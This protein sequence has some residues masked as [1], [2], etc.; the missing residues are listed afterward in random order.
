MRENDALQIYR[1]G[2]IIIT[3]HIK[4]HQP[5]LGEVANFGEKE[6]FSLISIF[7]ATPFDMIAQLD[8]VGIDFTKITD[9]ELFTMMIKNL[10]PDQS[11]ILFGDVNF[12][13]YRTI[14][15]ENG[16]FDLRYYD[17]VI[18]EPV[19]RL[20]AKY[21]RQIHC[22]A[23]PKYEKVGNEATRK[24]MI[25]FAKEDLKYASRKQYKSQ[26]QS[27]ISSLV[28]HPNFKYGYYEIW[29]MPIGAFYDSMQRIHIIENTHNLYQAM[30]SGNID[31]SKINKKELNWMRPIE[32]K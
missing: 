16:T 6:Y 10:T 17:S 22:L 26:L 23:P 31:M 18:S 5:T 19:Y 3:D 15:H 9:F 7:T 27:I 20:M 1:G 25:E 21:I 29:D 8:E 14:Q 2:D 13:E 30:Y 24:K 12:S 28:N 32:F 4:L 11:G